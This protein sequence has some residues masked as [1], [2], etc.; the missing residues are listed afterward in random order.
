MYL[1][2]NNK[3]LYKFL[4]KGITLITQ[5]LT[6]N[7]T[8]INFYLNVGTSFRELFLEEFPFFY[9]IILF[10]SQCEYGPYG[11]CSYI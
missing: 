9:F 2:E 11:A 6:F 3:V 4:S 1:I 10:V 8:G 5:V 7:Y